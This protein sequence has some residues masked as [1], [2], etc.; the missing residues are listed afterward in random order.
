MILHRYFARRFALSFLGVLAVFFAMLLLIDLVEE[1]RRF[2]GSG[3]G[4]GTILGLAAL[5]IPETLYSMLPLITVIATILLF[6]ALA[7]SSELV[8]TRAVGRSALRALVAPIGVTLVIGALAIGVLNPLVAVT[9]QE[10]EA[11]AGDLSGED[12]ALALSSDGLW[13]RQ[14]SGTAQSVIRAERTNLDGTMLEGVTMITFGPEGGP[15]RRIEAATARL[16]T[17]A[18]VLSDAKVWPLGLTGMVAEA[19]AQTFPDLTVPSSLTPDQIRDSFGEPSSI[20]IWDL[21]A[22]I[23]RLRSAGFAATRHEVWFQMELAMPA[24][25]VAMT[26][27][28]AAF[29]MR[30]QRGGHTGVMVLLAVLLCFGV[31]F[32]RNFAR[33]LGENGEIPAALAAWA[34][35]VA[36]ILLTLAVILHLEDG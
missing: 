15:Q 25:L 29:T 28:G 8:V 13:L 2:G 9:S 33:I 10:Y 24:F 34:P 21:P 16:T 22:F 20:P 12:R 11:R 36:A 4:F 6:L 31:Y 27:I 7:R 23:E 18:W 3:A 17:G 1:A 30:H 14:G 5:A 26:L 32:I 19:Q 35:P